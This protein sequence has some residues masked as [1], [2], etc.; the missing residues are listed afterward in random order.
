MTYCINAHASICDRIKMLIIRAALALTRQAAAADDSCSERDEL[1]LRA[2][3]L[4][5]EHGNSILRLAYSYLHNYADAEEVLQDTLIN[6]VRAKPVFQNSRHAR[7]WLLRVAANL[8]KNA[9]KYKG[10][11]ETDELS[12][13][14]IA[15]EKEDLS[16]VWEAVREL[17]EKYREVIHLYYYEGFSTA[18]IS[19]ALGRSES[20]VRSELC[21]GRERLKKVLREDYDFE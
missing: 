5:N 3:E 16:F 21:R 15:E 2:E 19:Q 11:H 8:S 20:S 14:L 10:R 4:L 13:S 12:E 17:P 7:A 6:F 1:N 9:L 18:D